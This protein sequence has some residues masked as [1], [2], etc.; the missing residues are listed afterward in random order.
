YLPK[1]TAIGIIFGG[2]SLLFGFS[3]VWHIWWLAIASVLSMLA[4]IVIRSFSDDNDY[5]ISAAEIERIEER[6]FKH[7]ESLETRNSEPTN[8]KG[9]Q[10]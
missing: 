3:M 10:I 2:F 1:N 6:R 5:R 9:V 4:S 7:R 8:L